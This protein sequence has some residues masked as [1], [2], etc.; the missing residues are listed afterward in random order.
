[1]FPSV[2]RMAER[3]A[4]VAREEAAMPGRQTLLAVISMFPSV[5]RMA[6][7]VRAAALAPAARQLVVHRPEKRQ[8]VA[9][10]PEGRAPAVELEAQV[11]C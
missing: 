6:V 4:L 5:A 2:A 9:R 11:E 8:P 7:S 10:P 1:M 3:P